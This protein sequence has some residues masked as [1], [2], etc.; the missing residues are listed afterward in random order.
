M[1]VLLQRSVRVELQ[2][3]LDQ[4]AALRAVQPR[5]TDAFNE[6]VAYACEH[7]VKGA[8]ELHRAIY[9]RLRAHHGLPSQF[10]CNVQ[11]SAMGAVSALRKLAD[12]GKDVSVPVSKRQPIPYDVRTMKI[13][14]DRRSVTLTTLG[15]RIEVRILKHKRIDAYA[16]WDTVS[17][18][19]SFKDGRVWLSLTFTKDVAV[20][21]IT[22][23]SNVIGVDRGIVVPAA[24]STGRMLGGPTWH[25]TDRNHFRTTR[26]LQRKGTK[27]AKRRLKKRSGKWSRFRV[28][29]DHNITKQVVSSVPRGS[30]I[31]LE[32]LTNIR[33]RCRGRGPTARRRMHAWSF[34]RQQ[35]MLGYKAPEYGVHVVYVDARYTSQRCSNCGHTDRKNRQS[36]A[37]FSCKRCGHTENADLNAAKNIAANWT[38]SHRIGGPPVA[39][40]KGH[41][42]PPHVA[43]VKDA[44]TSKAGRGTRVSRAANRRIPSGGA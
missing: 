18:E 1:N 3:T 16:E 8:V 20:D 6:A 9:K 39:I 21:P 15:S 22:A 14:P 26:S 34:R 11:R 41:V 10:A 25:Q 27:S 35:E 38:T 30:I 40:R 32:N 36:Q 23:E 31:A 2:V 4:G 5:V 13:R 29:C 7:E 12:A 44:R 33:L 42:N 37:V 28:W 17:G 24:L 43:D 19:V